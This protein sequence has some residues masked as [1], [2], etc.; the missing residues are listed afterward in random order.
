MTSWRERIEAAKQPRAGIFVQG[1]T[2]RDRTQAGD[3][4]TCAVG[5]Q[6][7]LGRVDTAILKD[8]HMRKLGV[9]FYHAVMMSPLL[10]RFAIRRAEAI[11]EAIENYALELDLQR[12][13]AI[14]EREPA[15]R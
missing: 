14:P 12:A 4:S 5:E 13:L 8:P 9:K 7:R 15:L 3:W 11:F 6:I 1:F 2:K 10:G